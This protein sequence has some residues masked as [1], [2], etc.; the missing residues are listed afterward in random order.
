MEPQA[1]DEQLCINTGDMEL[2][3]AKTMLDGIYPVWDVQLAVRMA[4]DD[5]LTAL[6]DR[7]TIKCIERGCC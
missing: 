6:E 2:W 3:T 7:N 4:K 1:H 5:H